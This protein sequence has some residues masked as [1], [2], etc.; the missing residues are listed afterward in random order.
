MKI[1][2]AG[3]A[4]TVTGSCYILEV[5]GHRFAIDCGMYQGN[6][7]IEK[8]NWDM[9]I[10]DPEHIEFIVITHAHIDHSG[11]LPRLVQKGF[12]GPIYTTPPTKDL[13]KI[14]LLDS[15]HIQEMEAFWKTKRRLRHGDE[16]I[17]PL[18]TQA[19]AEK[20]YPLIKTVGYNEVFEPCSDIKVNLLDA[21]HILGA[22]HIELWVNDQGKTSKLVFSGDVGRPDQLLVNDPSVIT[23]ADFLL[24][25][26]TYGNRDHKSDK[27]SLD[28]L[29]E[30]IAYSY[31]QGEKV[32]IP[33]FAVQRTQEMIYSLHLLSMDGRLPP[34]LPVIIDSPL[35][36][37]ATEV[38][39]R[40]QGYFDEETH[41]RIQKGENPLKL[42]QMR[43][44]LS[45]Q[46]SMAINLMG[47]AVVISASGMAN[48]GRIKHHLRHNLW[49]PGA[50]IVFAGF[51][52][53]GTTGR[54][55]VDGAEKVKIFNEDIAVKAKIFTINRFSSHAGQS[56]LLDWIGHFGNQ[57]MQIFLIH[58]EYEAQQILAELI[59]KRF[60]FKVHIPDYLEESVLVAGREA[61]YAEFPGK[62][63]P[64]IDWNYL[65][66]DMESKMAT[67]RDRTKQIE[68]KPWVDQTD[69]RDHL[70]EVNSHLLEILSQT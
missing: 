49:R 35:A 45:T 66:S 46:E 41:D 26:S 32:I 24:V 1:K 31:E 36:I 15:A 62:A 42:P 13:L 61:T 52:A 47:P 3:A 70:V 54:R 65:L 11:L 30:A 16:R 37:R 18:Y 50:S 38:F 34:D 27:E 12:R 55:I 20:T 56:Q 43:C 51:Q 44:T 9:G 67:L 8:R 2:F 33:S 60:G 58:G 57:E 59:V 48:A 5:A 29:A 22:A 28:E 14:M 19:D 17:E 6:E 68:S 63:S 7:E 21:G 10:Y 40:W 69:L 25:E 39:Q 4:R 23:E 64:R 53:Q